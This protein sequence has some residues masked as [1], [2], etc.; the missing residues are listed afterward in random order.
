MS[1]Q[2]DPYDQEQ[3]ETIAY[4][5]EQYM[6]ILNRFLIL[7]NKTGKEIKEAKNVIKKAIS[8]LRKGKVEK[9][10]DLDNC[11]FDMYDDDEY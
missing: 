6:E 7:P 8:N 9:V 11:D 3:N 4:E 5:L 2:F 1:K 10:Y